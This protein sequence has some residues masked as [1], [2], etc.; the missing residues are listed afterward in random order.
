[1]GDSMGWTTL[2]DDTDI[3]FP[4]YYCSAVDNA[5]AVDMNSTYG[6]AD[7]QFLTTGTVFPTQYSDLID[8]T[9]TMMKLSQDD[10]TAGSNWDFGG[11][12]LQTGYNYYI[13]SD[14]N[15]G[16]NGTSHATAWLTVAKVNDVIANSV[17]N[18]INGISSEKNITIKLLKENIMFLRCDNDDPG[19]VIP[20][21]P[22]FILMLNEKSS[23]YMKFRKEMKWN[24]NMGYIFVNNPSDEFQCKG[25][26]LS[27]SSMV[28]SGKWCIK[29]LFEDGFRRILI[30]YMTGIT[31]PIPAQHLR[32][33]WPDIVGI[34]EYI[35]RRELSWVKSDGELFSDDKFIDDRMM[36]AID[37]HINQ[38]LQN[39]ETS[40]S[41]CEIFRDFFAISEDSVYNF[42]GKFIKITSEYMSKDLSKK[43]ECSYNDLNAFW[44]LLKG[45]DLVFTTDTGSAFSDF[46]ILYDVK[47][48]KIDNPEI[49]EYINTIYDELFRYKRDMMLKVD[50][51]NTVRSVIE[52]LC[53]GILD[54]IQKYAWDVHNQLI[55]GANPLKNYW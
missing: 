17:I 31:K 40:S 13:R 14:G 47:N 28:T 25:I 5:V 34:L 53:L 42:E 19:I 10:A 51:L 55:F 24:A 50:F 46:G 6:W 22:K 33:E 38:N 27:L 39:V 3:T 54:S 45:M 44:N 20:A 52:R 15:D 1:M 8:G 12:V 36:K 21:N 7:D 9:L 18:S 30:N 29:K 4:D 26:R 37:F 43:M 11:T 23:S 32:N 41:I 48:W 16:S 49:K 2:D 35:N